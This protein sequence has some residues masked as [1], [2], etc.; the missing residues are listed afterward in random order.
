METAKV[1][2]MHVQLS[3]NFGI[4]F[5]LAEEAI[6][7]TDSNLAEVTRTRFQMSVPITA[8]RNIS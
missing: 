4:R 6:C 2:L 7:T 3:V 1:V 8:C 5:E